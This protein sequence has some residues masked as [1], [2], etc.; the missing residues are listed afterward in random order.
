M[1][2]VGALTQWRPGRV[3][4]LVAGAMLTGALVD[5]WSLWSQLS[6]PS[7]LETRLDWLWPASAVLLSTAAWTPRG[8]SPVIRLSGLRPLAPPGGGG[9]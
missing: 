7:G 9:T 4:G 6:G 8:P 2:W 5:A 1:L 3:L